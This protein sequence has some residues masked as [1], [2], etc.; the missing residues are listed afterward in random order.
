MTKIG[1]R[2]I[3]HCLS[4]YTISLCHLN[5]YHMPVL[6]VKNI[7][8]YV[9]FTI[10]KVCL[11]IRF[12]LTYMQPKVVILY[13]SYRDL[14]TDS[15]LQ[16]IFQL[17]FS[18]QPSSSSYTLGKFDLHFPSLLPAGPPAPLSHSLPINVTRHCVP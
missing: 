12:Y 9:E 15:C 3:F 14:Q 1:R 6:P 7:F 8:S 11:H 18:P 4:L 16:L 5:F 2:L 13:L 17:P 10:F